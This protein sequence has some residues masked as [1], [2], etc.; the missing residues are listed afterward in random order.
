MVEIEAWEVEV[1]KNPN[2]E[3]AND[4]SLSW[5]VLNKIKFKSED[6]SNWGEFRA[7]GGSW[8]RVLNRTHDLRD[9]MSDDS[10]QPNSNLKSKPRKRE[11]SS[12]LETDTYLPF[13]GLT[14][15]PP[16]RSGRAWRIG[17]DQHMEIFYAK[18][19]P[20]VPRS[21]PRSREKLNDDDNSPDDPKNANYR[22]DLADLGTRWHII[23]RDEPSAAPFQIGDYVEY[24]HRGEFQIRDPKTKNVLSQRKQIYLRVHGTYPDWKYEKFIDTT[25]NHMPPSWELAILSSEDGFQNRHYPERGINIPYGTK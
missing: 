6:P 11:D 1:K 4:E 3:E 17:N 2:P 13:W 7:Y 23:A 16:K 22:E 20:R 10:P 24:W 18:V 5:K 14:Q 25:E 19:V 21:N 8:T 15:G 9:M 12:Q